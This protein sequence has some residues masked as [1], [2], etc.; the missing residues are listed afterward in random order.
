MKAT[1]LDP[2]LLTSTDEARAYGVI[3]WTKGAV[4]SGVV[5]APDSEEWLLTAAA[6][7][8]EVLAWART[9]AEGRDFEILALSPG[10]I[11]YS[12]IR[13]FGSDPTEVGY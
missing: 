1:P 2:R 11:G 13:L 3:F 6:D 8:D 10:A 12:A 7:I 9:R 4:Q 5:V